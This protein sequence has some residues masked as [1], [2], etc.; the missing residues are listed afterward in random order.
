MI[1]NTPT[2]TTDELTEL[3][4]EGEVRNIA[5]KS[6]SGAFSYFLRTILLNGIGLAT[7]LILSGY[8][9]PT[10]FGV[11]GYVT[12]F[13]GL[14]VFFSDVGL[15]ASLIQKKDE[16]SIEE[17]RTV[18]T[19]QQGLAWLIF[20]IVLIIVWSGI[21]TNTVGA[22]GNW[23]LLALGVSFPLA[24]FKTISS[25][26]LER[27][28]DFSKLVL[29]QIFEQ[30]IF[31]GGLIIGAISGFGVISYA[32]AIL[33][34]SIGGVVVM[35]LI[36]PW[37]IGLVLPR[38]KIRGLLKFGVQFQANDLL[39]R[40]KDN[41]FYIFLARLMT[42]T[43]YG[44]MT[45]AKNWSM[46]PYNLTVGNVMAITFPTF[47]RLQKNIDFLKRAIEKSLFFIT[48]AIFPVIVAMSVFI[49]PLT[50]LIDKYQKWQPALISF[51]FFT[52]GIGWSA[53]SS[54]L[55]NTLN[56]I[57]KVNVTLKLMTMWTALTWLLIPLAIRW[58]GFNGVA[59]ASFVISF[60]SVL[61]AILVKKIVP[62]AVWPQIWR[63]LVAAGCMAVVGIWGMPVWRQS[64]Q[65]VLLGMIYTG[66]I[67]VIVM[68]LLGKEKVFVELKTLRQKH[69]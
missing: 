65:H 62:I 28:L 3:M 48:L 15:A 52:L 55:T 9:S 2:D 21:I 32:Y 60:T 44:Y 1:H 51:V 37:P 54:P 47:S 49:F 67:F 46:Y 27:K 26:Q 4:D 23:V 66:V 5:K 30:V 24:S 18:F 34:R 22:A 7:A 64:L 45:W 69:E 40:L 8:L 14:L 11:Y 59:I 13:I 19:I 29:P 12:Q 33:L 58:Y 6:I 36:Q 63:Q 50:Q 68:L 17:Y 10:D 20:A 31:N 42:P 39:A 61:P 25:I 38:Q 43:E 16:P 35:W 41:L 56:A 57:G 53:L